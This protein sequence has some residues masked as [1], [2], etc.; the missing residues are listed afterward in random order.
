M[1]LGS[2]EGDP[3]QEAAIFGTAPHP[4]QTAAKP[5]EPEKPNHT[6][7]AKALLTGLRQKF[8]LPK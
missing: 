8:L 3:E 4:T 1:H 6:H 5:W 2:L 7:A